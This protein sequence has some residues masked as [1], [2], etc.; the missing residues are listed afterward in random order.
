MNFVADEGVDRLIVESL[1]HDGHTVW[2]VA[3][4]SPSISDEEVL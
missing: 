4:M 3:E 2:Y 1:R